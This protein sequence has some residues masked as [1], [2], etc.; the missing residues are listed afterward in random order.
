[1][2]ATSQAQGKA[3]SRSSRNSAIELLR[4]VAMFAIVL[5]HY[6]VHGGLWSI[7]GYSPQSLAITAGGSWG[8]WGVD[9]FILITGYFLSA[10]NDL[11]KSLKRI[12]R[13]YAQVWTTSIICMV[14]VILYPGR[15][16]SFEDAV[17][18]F[19]PIGHNVW[20][21]ATGY[22]VLLLL[23]PFINIMISNMSRKQ[24][25][26]MMLV[27]LAI[28]SF[29][30]V[31]PTANYA[32]SL[33]LSLFLM[34]YIVGA[35]IRR[36]YVATQFRVSLIISILLLSLMPLLTISMQILSAYAPSLIDEKMY[37]VSDRSPL[38]IAAA[39]TSLF[40]ALSI[41]KF[42]SSTINTISGTMFGVY[43]LT[44]NYL[45]RKIIWLECVQT[46]VQFESGT[47]VY[48]MLA[49]VLSVFI[50]FSIV[51]MARQKLIQKRIE[52][53]IDKHFPTLLALLN[54]LPFVNNNVS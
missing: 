18:G 8:K 9:V 17:E 54:K 39:V 4:I 41:K 12:V 21:F 32:F 6:C 22:F 53:L 50:I 51:E 5:H 13:F 35:Y 26:S 27:M 47:I 44:D 14:S 31:I 7:P 38:T 52:I 49:S 15:T 2:W 43:L 25:A 24:H 19:L 29:S 40:A 1:L 3:M 11:H 23:S 37:L 16:I 34:L 33:D 36:H 48:S 46:K 20:W 28:W 42:N 30:I 10:D 45:T